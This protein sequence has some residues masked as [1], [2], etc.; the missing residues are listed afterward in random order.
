MLNEI[1]NQSTAKD[2]VRRLLVSA[3]WHIV[4]DLQIAT[5]W[6]ELTRSERLYRKPSSHANAIQ[7]AIRCLNSRKATAKLNLDD[8]RGSDDMVQWLKLLGHSVQ[9]YVLK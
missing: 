4:L 9:A 7:E 5:R 3:H 2:V 8:M 6:R 1:I